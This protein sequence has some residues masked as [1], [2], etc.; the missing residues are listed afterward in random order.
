MTIR[1]WDY[2]QEYDA[3]R[4][5]ILA[6]VDS[7]FRSGQL[8]LGPN[9]SAFEAAFAK[10]CG[11]AHGV[12]VNS[13][14]DALVLALK[15]LGIKDGDEVLTVP[16]TAVPTVSA[17]VSA[18]GTPRFVD[19]DPKT[20]LMDVAALSSALTS[21]TRLILPV[22]L[23]GQCVDMDPLLE[24]AKTNG[25]KVI[26]DCAQ[27]A[28][29]EYKGR[30]AGTMG[31]AAAFSFYPTKNL[32]AYGDAGMIVTDDADTAKR[33]RRL[34]M[35][36]MA[37]EYRALEHGY[38]SRLDEIHAA[39]LLVKL[40]HLDEWLQR[41]RDLAALYND[42]LSSAALTLPVEAAG[43]RHTYH[44]YVVRHKKR[45]AIVAEMRAQGVA[46]GV[47]YPYPI[48]TMPAYEYLKYGEGDLPGSEQLAKEVFSLP[49]Y[50]TM[51]D[52]DQESISTMLVEIVKTL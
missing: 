35:Y 49:L 12:G 6:A 8:M 36:G 14:T 21:R 52:E 15:A 27:A 38:N 1:T 44:L 34:R 28:G 45:D 2:R 43:N 16:N 19:V 13:G 5:E 3:I 41:R 50:P 23:Y 46:I 32:G 20:C 25:L 29:A 40:E 42:R 4:D 48:H 22:H 47:N 31:D 30:K 11:A 9:V 37:D 24:L 18:G 10:Y 33:V 39:I 7:V 17:I 51:A 26:E